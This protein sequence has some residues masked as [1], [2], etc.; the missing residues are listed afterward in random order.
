MMRP[1]SSTLV[2]DATSIS[3]VSG[4]ISTSHTCAPFGHDGVDGVSV[5]DTRILRSGARAATSASA[6]E[7]SV[8][9]IANRPSRYSMSAAELSSAEQEEIALRAG[10]FL[11]ALGYDTFL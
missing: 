3:P 9:A 5:A 10:P 7:R 1:M 2:I 8:P 11:E 6:S 4:S